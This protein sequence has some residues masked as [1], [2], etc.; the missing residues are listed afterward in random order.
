MT[1]WNRLD[2]DSMYHTEP[3]FPLF[4]FRSILPKA[5]LSKLAILHECGADKINI[6]LHDYFIINTLI[7]SMSHRETITLC[8]L[9]PKSFSWGPREWKE[10]WVELEFL[11]LYY[12]YYNFV[13]VFSIQM[14][15]FYVLFYFILLLVFF[16]W[17]GNL[18]IFRTY[19]W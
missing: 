11:Y 15:M 10:S 7:Y 13:S 16:K 1:Q 9:R 5:P 12:H 3:S 2:Q 18:N 17:S 8:N 6:T 14:F 4:A 19:Y